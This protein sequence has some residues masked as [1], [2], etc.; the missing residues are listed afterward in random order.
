M[1][2]FFT[3]LAVAATVFFASCSSEPAKIVE[4][5]LASHGIEY[6][7][8]APEGAE[9]TDG[10]GNIT[11]GDM[12][13][14]SK[15]IKKDDFR[16]NVMSFNTPNQELAAKLAEEKKDAQDDE[17]FVEIIKED[18]NGFIFKTKTS[19]GSA[20]DFRKVVV[21]E[22]EYIIIST[23]LNLFGEYSEEEVQTMY[24]TL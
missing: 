1:K 4:L 23:A 2:K 6:K 5:D 24:N 14:V 22:N 9:V 13:V 8:N 3:S 7:V 19:D 10:L 21:K 11:L 12:K 16:I 17:D 18:Q 20:Y 15:E